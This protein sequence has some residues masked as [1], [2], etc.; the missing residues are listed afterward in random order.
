MKQYAT[1]HSEDGKR[2][3]VDKFL[4]EL[5]PEYSRSAL[6]KL[7]NLNLI[8]LNGE[9]LQPGFH[10]KPGAEIEYDISALQQKPAV[11]DLPI[12]YEDKNIIVINKPAGVISHARGMF[13]QEASV[14]SFIRD[15]IS[16]ELNG[17][18]GGIVHR[19]DRATSGVMICAKNEK[20]LRSLQLSFSKRVVEKTYI[21]LLR[22]RP[23]QDECIVEAPIIRDLKTPKRFTVDTSGKPSQT[24]IRVLHSTEMRTLVMLQ[25]KTGRTHQLRVHLQYIGCPIIGDPLYA[26]DAT[27][28]SEHSNSLRLH[29]LS[30]KVPLD[31]D[32]LSYEAEVPEYWELDEDEKMAIKKAIR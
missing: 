13:W 11:I 27:K 26:Y 1:Y 21:A 14:A 3:R 5:L 15:K 19:L 8:K 18:R 12:I 2:I 17:E 22:N 32:I 9:S 25:P 31:G 16:K 10:L 28:Y 30:I 6:S 7:F 23:K 20:T 4:S 29:A 24:Y